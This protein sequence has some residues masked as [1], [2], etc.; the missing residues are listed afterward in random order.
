MRKTRFVIMVAVCLLT[1]AIYV[2]AETRKAGL[3]ETTNTMTWQQSPLPGGISP[4]GNG[5][6]H[7]TQVC[8]TQQELEKYGAIAPQIPGCQVTNV[9]VKAHGMTADMVC[10]GMMKGKGTLESSWNDDSHAIGSIHFAGSIQIGTDNK[11]IEWTIHST[12]AFKSADCGSV[13][14][15]PPPQ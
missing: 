13:K 4:P 14:P 8:L 12:S 6:P 9:I 3:W 10:D 1:T 2:W 11:P 7:T 15:T 5:E